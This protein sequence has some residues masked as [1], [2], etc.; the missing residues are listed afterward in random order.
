MANL[1]GRPPKILDAEKIAELVAKGYTVEFVAEYFGVAI[2]TLYLNYSDAIRK[3]HIFRNSCLQAVQYK[4]AIEGNVTM[5][6]W[7]GKQW[8]KQRD[9][10]KEPEPLDAK[11]QVTHILSEADRAQAIKV[12]QKLASYSQ[13]G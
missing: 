8:L 3:G 11:G 9:R 1:L 6:I 4:G 12:A 7:L 2:S 5:Q 13:E 10:E